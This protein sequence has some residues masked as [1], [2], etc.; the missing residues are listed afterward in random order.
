MLS[1]VRTGDVVGYIFMPRIVPRVK[2]LFASGFGWIAFMMAYVF[3]GVRL[4]PRN[5]PYLRQAN[6]GRYGVRHVIAEAANRLE[7]RRDNLDQIVVFGALLLGFVLLV[8]Q[9]AM[10]AIAFLV[11]P[12]F[13]ADLPAAPSGFAGF[14]KTTQPN[15]DIAFEL[16]DKVFAIPGLFNSKYAPAE[17][18]IPGFNQGMQQLIKFYNM[19][20]LIVGVAI[21]LYY[22]VAVVAETANTGTPFG[23]RF[24]HIYAPLRLVIA[25][26]LLVPLNYGFNGAQYITLFAAKF[27]SSLATNTWLLFNNT[28]GDKNNPLGAPG[29]T[30]IGRPQ[31]PDVSGLVWSMVLIKAC[32]DAYKTNFTYPPYAHNNSSA[33]GGNEDID[34]EPYLVW[35]TSTQEAEFASTDYSTA[36]GSTMFNGH[37]IVVRFGHHSQTLFPNEQGYVYPYCGE[38]TIPITSVSATSSTGSGSGAASG[39]KGGTDEMQQTYYKLVKDLWNN[40]EVGQY[41]QRFNAVYLIRDPNKGHAENVVVSPTGPTTTGTGIGASNATPSNNVT[42]DTGSGEPAEPIRNHL[43]R[44][45][46]EAMQT[47]ADTARDDLI[48]NTDFSISNDIKVRGWAGAAIWYNRIAMWNGAYFG[49]VFNVPELSRPP[50]VMRKV[51]EERGRNNMNADA[52]N[53]YD[54]NMNGNGDFNLPAGE[55]DIATMENAVYQHFVKD[56]PSA[57]T[58]ARPDGGV[59]ITVINQVFPYNALLNIRYNVDVHPLAQLVGLGKSI[60]DSAI[61]HLTTGLVGLGMG[62]IMKGAGIAGGDMIGFFAGIWI[63]VATMTLAIGFTLY[64]VLP[65]MPFIYFFFAVGGW[66][67]SIFEAMVGVPLWA[68][69]HLRIDGDGLPGD[70]AME[71]YFLIFEI[72]LR[73][74]LILFG[75]L[76]GLLVFSAMARTLHD[77]FTILVAN[78]SGFDLTTVSESVAN[79]TASEVVA[80]NAANAVAAAKAYQGNAL[81][82]F[83]Y[84][85]VYTILLYSMALSSFKLIDQLPATMLRWLG[86][87]AKSFANG[88]GESASEF[89]SKFTVVDTLVN[90]DI[91]GGMRTGVGGLGEAVGKGLAGTKKAPPPKPTTGS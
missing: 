39:Q 17:G 26:G 51:E 71:G 28:I 40:P 69:A 60:I 20:M 46:D 34:V 56:V 35:G 54:P 47:A 65:F 16:L 5:H 49:A 77:I 41:A 53:R 62:G 3:A 86:T 29:E 78:V 11:H 58:T 88:S 81:D 14:F 73:P 67:K 42:A 45:E 12:A 79:G 52:D 23:R 80:T 13:A 38:I 59:L 64:Y 31:A 1:Q 55:D 22:I 43:L 27:G 21:F 76:G 57:R 84:T 32:A 72:F 24:S 75:L 25:V 68:L 4:L 89:M 37:D 87:G 74:V 10:F 18:S 70:R 91:I 30:L 61:S 90:Q 48:K 36:V 63:T 7:L 33:A 83:F 50:D 19:A 9:F 66:V 6:F 2:E 85:I 15:D 82:E 8:L 44:M